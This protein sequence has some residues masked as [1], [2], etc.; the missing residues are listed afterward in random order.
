MRRQR[1]DVLRRPR[2]VP[3]RGGA[4]ATRSLFCPSQA[5][6]FFSA[7]PSPLAGPCTR[8]LLF[9]VD[10][11]TRAHSP[12]PP[13]WHAW[14]GHS[15]PDCLLIVYR[16]KY[17]SMHTCCATARLGLARFPRLQAHGVPVSPCNEAPP[18]ISHC[19]MSHHSA[20]CHIPLPH[21]TSQRHLSYPIATC[22][23]T[24]PHVISHCHMSHTAPPVISR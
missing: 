17:P 4:E 11:C 19:H 21:V 24:V 6:G 22:H 23:I 15:F 18:V 2:A 13:P 1:R 20:T 10:R 16:C 8:P 14:H 7:L 9:I 3:L 5:L 12:H